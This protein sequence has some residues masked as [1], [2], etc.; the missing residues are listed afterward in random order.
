MAKRTVVYV[1]CDNCGQ[2]RQLN[3]AHIPN[4]VMYQKEVKAVGF[5]A[6][7]D[8]EYCSELCKSQHQS[9]K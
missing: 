5:V 2:E 1:I 9:I 8:H 3:S 4:K 7:K 6:A